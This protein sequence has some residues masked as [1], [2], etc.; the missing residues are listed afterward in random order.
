MIVD[1]D[2]SILFTVQAILERNG[3][4]VTAVESGCEC[5]STLKSGFRGL[6]LMDV[7]MPG[8]SGWETIEA[9]REQGLTEGN[10]VCMMTVITSPSE[11]MEGI[12]ELV[13]D[14]L[15]KPFSPD[16]LLSTV[17]ECFAYLS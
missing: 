17:R 7:M 15:R 9:I 16:E 5:L 8:M 11:E 2:P 6:I 3:M 14:Y 4:S 13:L 10:I 1:D 12:K